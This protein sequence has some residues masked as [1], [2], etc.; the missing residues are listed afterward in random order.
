MLAVVFHCPDMSLI[1]EQELTP[2]MDKALHLDILVD[3]IRGGQNP[4]LFHRSL[5][6]FAS[7]ARFAPSAVLHNVMPIFT[8]MGSDVLHRDDSYSFRVVQ[9]V[10]NLH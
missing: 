4:Q 7:V 10:C 2:N 5:L 6:L 1:R 8:F 3:L 9:K